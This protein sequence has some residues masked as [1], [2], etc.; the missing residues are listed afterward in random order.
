MEWGGHATVGFKTTSSCCDDDTDLDA[1][2][3]GL[4]VQLR[5]AIANSALQFK[6]QI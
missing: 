1:K 3:E 5:R 4:V 6:T 2:S